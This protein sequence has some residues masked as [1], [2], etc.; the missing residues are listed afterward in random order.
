MIILEEGF[1]NYYI[2]PKAVNQM[3]DDISMWLE[4]GA[5]PYKYGSEV[6]SVLN[7]LITNLNRGAQIDMKSLRDFKRGITDHI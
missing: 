7:D 1:K 2:N 5:D 3:Y 6:G 4:D